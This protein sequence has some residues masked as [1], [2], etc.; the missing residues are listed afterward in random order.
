MEVSIMGFFTFKP[1]WVVI[2]GLLLVLG[3]AVWPSTAQAQQTNYSLNL[4]R[5]FGYSSGSQIRGNFTASIVGLQDN[6]NIQSV[7]YLIDG[8][9]IAEV[10]TAPFTLKFVTTDYPLGWHDMS[11]QI[12]TKDGQT[13]TTA[14]RR[15]EFASADQESAAVK[16]ITFPLLGGVLLIVIIA[17]GAQML[18][19]RKKPKLDL[20]LGSSRNYGITGGTI[21]PRCHR[22][23]ALHWW[24]FNAGIG[25][26]LDRCDFCGRW[27]MVRRASRDELARA[28]AAELEMAQPEKPI[29]AE[30]E[31][32]KL[33]EMLDESR[34]TDKS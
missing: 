27:G 16:N 14:V 32:Q 5:D 18:V 29:Q 2:T 21:C 17:L 8:K 4:S 26:K 12:Q 13:A 19:L 25:S 31:E 24:A 3:L 20:P 7:T 23:F 6:D 33:K 11:A 1:R 15:F 34:Y 28:E 9:S 22:P 10:T 30:S